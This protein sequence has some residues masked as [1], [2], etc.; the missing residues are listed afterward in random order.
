MPTSL[1]LLNLPSSID[2][3]PP[4]ANFLDLSVRHRHP[5]PSRRL[6]PRTLPY[7]P[8]ALPLFRPGASGNGLT[9]VPRRTPPPNLTSCFSPNR[10]LPVTPPVS[11]SQFFL[12]C[13]A[14]PP[15]A[16]SR[17]FQSSFFVQTMISHFLSASLDHIDP[18]NGHSTLPKEILV[19]SRP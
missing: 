17:T 19:Q 5:R 1:A 8:S 10:P 16:K 11:L 9:P 2:S 3:F 15:H 18:N 4:P 13:S 12:L 14:S 6:S 7:G